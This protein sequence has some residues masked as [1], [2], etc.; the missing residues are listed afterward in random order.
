LF[1]G[2]ERMTVWVTDDLN[3]VPVRIE[4]P[5]VVGTVKVDLMGYKNLRYP[6]TALVSVR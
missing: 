2:G 1:E 3:K 4:S 6:L 5:I